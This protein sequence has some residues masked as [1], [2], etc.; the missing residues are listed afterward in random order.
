MFAERALSAEAATQ[1]EHYDTVAGNYLA[2]LSYPH[3]QEYMAFLDRKLEEALGPARMGTAAEICCGRGEAFLIYGDRID[4]GI[5]IDISTAML[6]AARKALPDRKFVF[7][8]GNATSLPI[9]D[10]SLDTIFML[11]GIHHVL[12][13]ERLFCEIARVLKQGGRFVFREPFDDFILWRSIR[14]IIY[15]LSPALDHMTERPLRTSETVEPLEQVGLRL[16]HYQSHGFLGFC[17]FMN[18]D[19]LLLNSAFRFMPRVRVIVRAF[20]RLDDWIVRLP[21]LRWAG[22]QIIGVAV[23]E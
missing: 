7:L 18:S 5:G 11:G 1:R 16:C 17:L 4:L 12:N 22:L 19:I 8:Q 13:R 3:T 14:W 21:G 20:S 23:K 9:A 15:R 2:N 6:L 10:D